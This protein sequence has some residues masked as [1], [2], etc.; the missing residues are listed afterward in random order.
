MNDLV[1]WVL[2]YLDGG[3]KHGGGGRGCCCELIVA[4]IALP[5]AGGDI[6]MTAL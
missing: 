3:D 6:F 4:A 2:G 1:W 5:F